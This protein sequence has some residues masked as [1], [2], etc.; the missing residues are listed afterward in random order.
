MLEHQGFLRFRWRSF[1]ANHHVLRSRGTMIP[2]RYRSVSSSFLQAFRVD[3][4]AKP[5]QV[6][7]GRKGPFRKRSLA[8]CL[9]LFRLSKNAFLYRSHLVAWEQIEPHSARRKNFF[10]TTTQKTFCRPFGHPCSARTYLLISLRRLRYTNVLFFEN[11]IRQGKSA[12]KK[13]AHKP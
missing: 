3:R 6:D 7:R 1:S 5:L 13:T 4:E 12:S 11:Y 8:C 10:E 9:V 2:L